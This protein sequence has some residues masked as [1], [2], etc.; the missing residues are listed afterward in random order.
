MPTGVL[1]GRQPRSPLLGD[2]ECRPSRCRT[3]QRHQTTIKQQPALQHVEKYRVAAPVKTE[4]RRRRVIHQATT[5]SPYSRLYPFPSNNHQAIRRP[6][7]HWKK[8]GYGAGRRK[9][10]SPEGFSSSNRPRSG[11]GGGSPVRQIAP[12]PRPH[13]RIAHDD[14]PI[15][16]GFVE[17]TRGQGRV[18]L[19]NT[20]PLP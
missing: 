19:L 17:Q 16:N 1:T 6:T 3:G 9:I 5:P 8:A 7:N 12:A 15:L 2:P 4:S 18:L 11:S 10:L 20:E 13:A 14:H